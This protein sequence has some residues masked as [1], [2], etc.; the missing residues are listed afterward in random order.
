MTMTDE[1]HNEAT[2]TINGRQYPVDNLS[3][4]AKANLQS[5]RFAEQEVQRLEA[6]L[7]L[8]RT[9]MKAYG[10]ALR[11]NLPKDS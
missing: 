7:A 8:T 4:E 9:A 5:Y 3:D 2:V 10:R 11:E 6:K 1:R